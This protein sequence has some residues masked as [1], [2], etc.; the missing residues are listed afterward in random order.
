MAPKV[1]YIKDVSVIP[2]KNI[3]ISIKFK[4]SSKMGVLAWSFKLNV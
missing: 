4:F 1:Q 3:H 2:D